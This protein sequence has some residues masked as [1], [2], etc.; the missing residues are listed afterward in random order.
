MSST[1]KRNSKLNKVKKSSNIQVYVRIRPL[2]LSECETNHK[3]YTRQLDDKVAILLD[4]N[5][6]LNA[7]E[8]IFRINRSREK[9]FTFDKVFDHD[10]EQP[11]IFAASTQPLI[12]GVT[13]GYNATVFAY[14]ATGAG[15]TYTM[16]GA[17]QQPGIMLQTLKEIFD[18]IQA[19]SED[20][21]YQVKL[22]YLE[23]YNELIRDLI[24]ASNEF[25]DVR[26]DS[27]KGVIVAGLSEL[28]VI[29]PEEVM[30]ILMQ[31]N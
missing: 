9:H 24:S 8:E 28:H 6:D 1:N 10:S 13:N 17:P 3:Y 31:S 20:R 4:P 30:D 29:S 5:V 26:E 16:L 11:D 23:I 25:L 19:N 2:T 27:V 12:D 15:K 14:G 7:P 22:S 18:C 21:E